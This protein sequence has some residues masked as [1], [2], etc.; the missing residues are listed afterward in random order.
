MPA[1][2]RAYTA[3]FLRANRQGFIPLTFRQFVGV[4]AHARSGL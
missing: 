1:I 4:M 3:H 2:R